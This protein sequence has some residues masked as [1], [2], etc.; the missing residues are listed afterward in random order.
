M[1]KN[2]G[3]GALPFACLFLFNP[4][5]A[6]V[7]LLPD[8]FGYIILYFSLEQYAEISGKISDARELFKR[9]IYVNAIKLITLFIIFGMVIDSEMPV[10]LLL[11]SFVL[12]IVDLVFIIP[13]YLK[14]FGG[15]LYTGER[16]DGE[17][18][19]SR[20]LK[21]MIPIS[22]NTPEGYARIIKFINRRR[23]KKNRYILSRTEKIRSSALIFLFV[24]VAGA[25]LPEATS[26]LNYRNSDAHV[27]YYDFVYLFRSVGI[28][29]VSIVGIVW[30]VKMFMYFRGFVKSRSL[31]DR[32]E[33]QYC[34]E[35]LPN[36]AYHIKKRVFRTILI[37]SFALV[38]SIDLFFDMYNITPDF[39]VGILMLLTAVYARKYLKE[40]KVLLGGSV[41]LT[42]VSA[43][44]SF[45]QFSF[46]ENYNPE[47]IYRDIDDYNAFMEMFA[48]SVA[49]GIVLVLFTVLLMFILRKIILRTTGITGEASTPWE[50]EIAQSVHGELTRSLILPVIFAI[51]SAVS[52]SVHLYSVAYPLSERF[53]AGCIINYACCIGLAASSIYAMLEIYRNMEFSKI[54]LE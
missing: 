24:K 43:F 50:R 46:H 17:Y 15:I 48:G 47:K 13:G 12:N 22:E 11:F 2:L 40:W 3:L 14:L 20:K 23:E 1:K 53:G 49:E 27:N 32:L 51:G 29:I 7:D 45:K 39:I 38:C 16:V 4:D 18:I 52:N 5:I 10:T 35:I 28:F 41:I 9:A 36:R 34:D 19:L 26:L 44:A 54:A 37:A 33:T 8:V 42:A 6:I 31:M 25:V 21:R 30:T